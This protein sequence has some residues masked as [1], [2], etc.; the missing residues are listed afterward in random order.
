L[1]FIKGLKNVILT[2]SGTDF[3]A[4]QFNISSDDIEHHRQGLF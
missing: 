4:K 1:I 2:E 3:F